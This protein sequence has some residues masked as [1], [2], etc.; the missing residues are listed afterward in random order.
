NHV[1]KF[2]ATH[3]IME[4]S[5]NGQTALNQFDYTRLSSEQKNP[6]NLS[7]DE[8]A[9]L[10]EISVSGR[11]KADVIA[12]NIEMEL[13]DFNRLNPGMDQLLS[14]GAVFQLKLPE[15]KMEIFEEKKYIILN[16]CIQQLLGN[17]NTD[18]KTIYKKRNHSTIKK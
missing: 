18:S 11:Y 1:K 4:S 6:V 15:D 12:N 16:E 3:Y 14:T 10:K 2:I 9:S 8:A 7:K 5:G 17:V 13:K